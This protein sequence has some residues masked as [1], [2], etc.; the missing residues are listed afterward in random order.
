M[1]YILIIA[2]SGVMLA[3][4]AKTA[5]YIPLV[6]DLFADVDTLYYAEDIVQVSSLALEQLIPA[7]NY[8]LNHYSIDFLVY[9]SGFENYPE[10]LNYLNSRLP[11]IGNTPQT[12]LRLQD[13]LAFFSVL[14]ELAIP[15]PETVYTAPVN[16]EGW[17]VK[18]E[19]SLGGAGI[20]RYR[21]NVIPE[22]SVYWQKFIQGS[23]CS[24]LFL[25]NGQ[26]AQAIG[27]NSQWT[28]KL[29][30]LDEFIFSGV[31]NESDLSTQQKMHV[32]SLLNKLVPVFELR[33]LNSLDFIQASNESLV[34][35]INPRVSASMQLY[36]VGLF[37]RHIRA[38]QGELLKLPHLKHEL[39]AYKIV[40][41][42]RDVLIPENL[43][44]SDGFLNIPK[45]GALIHTGQP[46]C[47][48]IVRKNS[49]QTLLTELQTK[50]SQLKW[51]LN[52]WN[53]KQA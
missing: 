40:F 24:V 9:G 14:D 7:V 20:K 46:I 21:F 13:K 12:F 31:I 22:S 47:S 33:G 28:V 23:S 45:P 30:E 5:G 51:F 48:M 25:A 15:Y 1:Q 17:L 16:T 50:E 26:Q 27:V 2:Q 42:D 34:L 53:K 19:R 52:S 8:F 43:N 35:E 39:S 44:W 10:S 18:P 36:D 3:Q 41:A 6:I 4:A 38:C 49:K 11:V 29:N 32:I 37:S